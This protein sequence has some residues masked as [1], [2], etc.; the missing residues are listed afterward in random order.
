MREIRLSATA[1]A[2]YQSCQRRYQLAY[3]FDLTADKDKDSTRLGG[4]WHRCHELLELKAG[5]VCPNCT[6]HEEIDSQCY[7]CGGT[8]YV[9]PDE[10]DRVARYLTQ[11][12]AIVPDNKTRDDWELERTIL[13]Y[14]LS[15]W[16]WL[17]AAEE[18][19]WEVIESEIKF[20]VPVANPT[21]G[22]ALSKVVFVGKIDRLVRDKN[23]GLV[24]VWE[25][26]STSHSITSQDYWTAL[27]QGD[28]ISG[29][30]AGG[31]HAQRI[32][33]LRPYGIRPED[34]PIA[35]AWCDVWHKPDIMPKKISKADLK[36]LVDTGEYCGTH[37]TGSIPLGD[38][39]IE[40]AEMY[41]A[42]LIQDIGERPEHYFAQREVSRT[43]KEL[44]VFQARLFKLA[45]QI[46]AIEKGD[47]WVENG[48]SCENPFYCEFRPLC[49]AGVQVTPGTAPVGYRLKHPQAE[50]IPLE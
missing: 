28:Q 11:A 24:Y 42:R 40:T 49:Q 39:V 6:R 18:G 14:S 43:D 10:M 13:L 22:R 20:E 38:S 32:G 1:N 16:K 37:I 33:C 19:R 45:K 9:L 48:R 30:L 25:R 31:R 23:T 5:T 4:H 44:E 27:T 41:G 50:E 12:Y 47:L 35:G 17:Y 7:V 8:G 2:D 34:T 29:Y 3:I 36:M 46:R 26:K 15:G 21:T